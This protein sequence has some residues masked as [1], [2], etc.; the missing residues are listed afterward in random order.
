MRKAKLTTQRNPE[1][2]GRE[3]KRHSEAP[4]CTNP[5]HHLT[6]TSSLKKKKIYLFVWLFRV[7]VLA[8]GILSGGMQDL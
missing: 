4:S 3:R 8:C 1:S 5:S 2:T 7:L 6:E